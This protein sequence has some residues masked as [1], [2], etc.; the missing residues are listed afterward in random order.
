MSLRKACLSLL[1]GATA[2]AA[3]SGSS[4]EQLLGRIKAR[5]SQNLNRLPNY[6][7]MTTAERERFGAAALA[8]CVA[9]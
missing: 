2:W 7:C 1:I 6:T 5:M 3:Q 4:P 9:L 8:P